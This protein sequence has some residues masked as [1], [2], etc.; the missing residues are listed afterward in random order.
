MQGTQNAYLESRIVGASPLELTSLLYQAAQCSVREALR[1]LSEND[2]AGR[3][4]RI[5]QAM[6]IVLE[7]RGSLD[8]SQGGDLSFRLA[9][10]YDYVLDRLLEAN[11]R[12][13]VEPLGEAAHVLETLAEAWA[14]LARMESASTESEA[15]TGAH[16]GSSATAA[17]H[18][19]SY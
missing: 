9:A 17:G 14:E 12:T 16:A 15:W 3:S 5:S 18:V 10:L 13:A 19:W 6:E 7:L 2:I 11:L 1:R 4:Q 8:F